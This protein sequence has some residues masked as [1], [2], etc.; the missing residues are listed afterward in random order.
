MAY[1]ILGIKL[2]HRFHCQFLSLY[3]QLLQMFYL[4]YCDDTTI[5]YSNKYKAD[6]TN[7]D[8]QSINLSIL[9]L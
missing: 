6:R 2:I 3:F 5:F 4:R 1:L 9:Y 8:C 7:I